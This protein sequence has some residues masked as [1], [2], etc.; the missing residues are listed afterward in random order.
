MSQPFEITI[1][2]RYSQNLEKEKVYGEKAV[3]LAYDSM[4]GR[5]IAPIIASKPVSKLYGAMMD[6]EFSV[7]KIPGFVKDYDINLDD[8]KAGSIQNKEQEKSYKTFNEFFIRE[9]KEGKREFV[10]D[11][12]KLAACAE[13]RYYGHEAI[14]DDLHIPVKG[15]MLHPLALL[16]KNEYSEAFIGGPVLIARL[17]PVDY[18]RYH[19]S[20]DG[21]T[22]VNYNIP[23]ELHSVNPLAL[24]YRNDIFISNERRVSIVESANFG[25]LAYIE[26]GATMVGK[27]VQSADE[28]KPHQRGD[29]KGYFLFGGSTVIVCGEAGKWRPSSDILESTKLGV[30][31]YIHLGDEMGVR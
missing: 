12:N 3:E 8:Y 7:H 20:D 14:T 21:E 10:A 25:K 31:T 11:T 6:T 22:L 23:G 26:V 24:K 9:F 13:A 17:C 5:T 28:S 1:N 15:N 16:G 4:L 29:E 27:I 18:H 30:E 2:N 19:Y